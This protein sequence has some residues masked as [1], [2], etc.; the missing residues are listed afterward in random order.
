MLEFNDRML[1]R[2]T[3]GGSL[4]ADRLRHGAAAV[5]LSSVYGITDPEE[6]PTSWPPPMTRRTS[7][8]TDT[9]CAARHDRSESDRLSGPY[10]RPVVVMAHGSGGTMDSGLEPFADRL[11]CARRGPT[12]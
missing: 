6:R 1:E 2:L 9:R 3:L 4:T 12:S 10:G 7:T 11:C 8:S 5:W